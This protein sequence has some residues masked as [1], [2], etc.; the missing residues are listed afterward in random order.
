MQEYLNKRTDPVAPVAGNSIPCDRQRIL[1]VDDDAEIREMFRYV[2]ASELPD[3]EIELCGNGEKALHMFMKLHHAVL[4]LDLHMPVMDGAKT[5]VQIQE[6]CEKQN[7]EMPSII[8]CTAYDPPHIVHEIVAQDKRHCLI[9]KPVRN[10]DLVATV[11][12][13]LLC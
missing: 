13:K 12:N 9:N 5:Y 11:K 1:I 10:E 3:Y 2:I 8:F 7:W 6:S 4:L